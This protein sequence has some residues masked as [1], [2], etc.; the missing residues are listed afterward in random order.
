MKTIYLLI[1]LLIPFQIQAGEDTTRAYCG[2]CVQLSGKYGGY[3]PA[4]YERMEWQGDVYWGYDVEKCGFL[5]KGCDLKCINGDLYR[6][7]KTDN[8][9]IDSMLL[10]VSIP[11]PT[12]DTITVCDTTW[13]LTNSKWFPS[14]DKKIA[15][16]EVRE[17]CRDTVVEV[18]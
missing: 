8:G 10:G 4:N 2:K 12:Y 17:H 6:I 5:E 15:Y 13:R 3:N 7:C 14:S 9:W 1:L 11:K 16:Y 18:K